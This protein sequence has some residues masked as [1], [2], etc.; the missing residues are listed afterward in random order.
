[1]FCAVEEAGQRHEPKF[2]FTMYRGEDP[3]W[4]IDGK[5]TFASF[6]PWC[7]Q[8]LPNRPFIEGE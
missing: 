3:C 4:M 6:C 8:R 5:T 2:E 1:M 7:G